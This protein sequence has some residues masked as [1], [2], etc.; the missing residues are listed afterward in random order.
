MSEVAQLQFNNHL[1]EFIKK[2]KLVLPSEKKALN[3]Y[4][5]YY[6]SYVDNNKRVD[7]INEYVGL[8]TQYNKEIS[9]C[10]EGLFSEEDDYYPNKPIHILKGIDFKKIWA[11]LGDSKGAV[12][13]YIQTLFLV[14]SF[15][16]K[17]TEK[18][19]KLSQEQEKLV[20]DLVQNLKFEKKIQEDADRQNKKEASTSADTNG[21]FNLDGLFDEDNVITQIAKELSKEINLGDMAGGDPIGML[22]GKDNGKLQEII[23]KVTNKLTSVLKEKGLSEQDLVVQ[24]TKMQEKIFGKLRGIPGMPNIEELSKKIADDMARNSTGDSKDPKEQLEQC[25]NTIR[26]LTESLKK[27]L[28]QMGMSNLDGTIKN[29]LGK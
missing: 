18:Y 8:I 5:K 4:Y 12:W 29:L 11:Q 15:V 9:I 21:T 26:D 7:F 23:S 28:S 22:L 3:S 10:D 13:K 14:G 27:N 1:V 17:E 6:R 16:L 2:L 25:Q 19:H 24:A 20:Y